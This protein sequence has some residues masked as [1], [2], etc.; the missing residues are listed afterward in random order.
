VE[1]QLHLGAE[2]VATAHGTGVAALAGL[3]VEVIDTDSADLTSLTPFDATLDLV[4]DPELP[5]RVTAPGGRATSLTAP[6][7][8]ELA[9]ERGVEVS[10]QATHVTTQRLDQ[11]SRYVEQGVLAPRLIASF[12]LEELAA[13]FARKAEGGVHGKIGVTVR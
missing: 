5:V 2:V 12:H 8:P 3:A 10:L 13:A 9:A 1:G 6:P 11:L 7:S 4:G